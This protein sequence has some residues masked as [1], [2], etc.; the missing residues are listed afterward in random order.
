MASVSQSA[1]RRLPPSLVL[2]VPFAVALVASRVWPWPIPGEAVVRPVGFVL[3]FVSIGLMYWA[4]SVMD[5]AGTTKV[6]WREGSTLVTGGPFARS[7]NPA[8]LAF[9]GWIVGASLVV[10]SWWPLAVLLPTLVAFHWLV[11]RP[12]EASLAAQ[13]GQEYAAYRTRVRRWL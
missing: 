4:T 11:V 6:A 1:P 5:A 7:R 12:E 10:A 3:V 2:L 9:V 13:F 8:Y